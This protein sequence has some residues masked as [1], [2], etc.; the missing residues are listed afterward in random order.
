MNLSANLKSIVLKYGSRVLLGPRLGIHV[1]MKKL[2]SWE[3]RAL[4]LVSSRAASEKK[5]E[6]A[7]S[8][9]TAPLIFH[10]HSLQQ[11]LTNC[12]PNIILNKYYT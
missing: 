9:Y 10:L 5:H 3:T 8:P 4:V 1:M 6:N 2:G 7:G 11:L 12:T